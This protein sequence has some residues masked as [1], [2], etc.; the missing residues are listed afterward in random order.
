LVDR[1]PEQTITRLFRLLRED[2]R[3]G[4]NG[5]YLK[6]VRVTA[7]FI[8]NPC[9]CSKKQVHTYCLTAFVI[10]S[11]KIYCEKCRLHYHL[12][13]SSEAICN[14]RFLTKLVQYIVVTLLLLLLTVASLVL[15]GYL[16]FKYF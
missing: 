11:R 7:S 15:D 12:W 14:Q 16:K 4:N 3:N 2:L 1:L 9:A 13:I 5:L 8:K 6:F 10:N